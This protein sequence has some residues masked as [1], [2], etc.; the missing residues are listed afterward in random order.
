MRIQVD[1]CGLILRFLQGL[2]LFEGTSRVGMA[3]LSR[4]GGWRQVPKGSFLFF[5]SDPAEDVFVLR[6]GAVSILLED[7]GGRELLINEIGP[8][9]CFG[10]VGVL[11]GLPR[12]TSAQALADSEVLVIPRY[13]FLAAVDQ[14]PFLVRR[15][16]EMTAQRLRDSSQ[17]EESL[18]FH[19]AQERVA[20]Q[21]LQLDQASTKGYIAISQEELAQR[22]GITRQTAAAIL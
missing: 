14:E 15:L 7:P 3:A 9:E 11:T 2:P 22:A 1:H 5:Q 16:L 17:R 6:R 20:R 13:A 8:G 12:S 4:A 19:D 21:L 10:E 18:A